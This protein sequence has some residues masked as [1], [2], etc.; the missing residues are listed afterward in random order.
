M[1]AE[2]AAT[3]RAGG[4]EPVGRRAV[5]QKGSETS[6]CGSA[7][8]RASACAQLPK[9][10]VGAD[11]LASGSASRRPSSS[12]RDSPGDNVHRQMMRGQQ[13]AL[14][15]VGVAL[16]DAGSRRG[17]A[18]ARD[19]TRL[20]KR[21]ALFGGRPRTPNRNAGRLAAPG[22][23]IAAANFRSDHARRAG[24]ARRAGRSAGP[25]L[26]PAAPPWWGAAAATGKPG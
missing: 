16:D 4:S 19:R 5:A 13:D 15:T 10:A 23:H 22:R 7:A 12:S 14:T 20:A 2:R 18:R 1:L 25:A 17:T 3:A 9:P 6:M 21:S 24:G 11:K 8:R 26:W